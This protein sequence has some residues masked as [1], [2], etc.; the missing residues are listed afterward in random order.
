MN[1]ELINVQIKNSTPGIQDEKEHSRV[2]HHINKNYNKMLRL[3]IIPYDSNSFTDTHNYFNLTMT[4]DQF[5]MSMKKKTTIF[6][7]TI[8]K[9]EETMK[10]RQ[11]I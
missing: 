2:L 6:G 8:L 4:A 9:K 11:M 10:E 1:A 5:N 7:D 3:L